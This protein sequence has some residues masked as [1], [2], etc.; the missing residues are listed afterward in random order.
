MEAFTHGLSYFLADPSVFL[1]LS[2]GVFFGI[3]FGAIPGLT[4]TLGV[5]LLLPFTYTMSPALGMSLL[6][7]IY[8]G[9]ISGGLITAILINI[10]GTPSSIITCFDGYPMAKNGRAGDALSIG[11]FASLVGGL[12]SA[13]ALIFISPPLSK[14]V[15][16]FGSWEYFTFALLGLSMV[17]SV[18]SKDIIKGLMGALLGLLLATVGMDTVT[19]MMRLT[20]GQWQLEGGISVTALMMGLFATREIMIQ[21]R[22]LGTGRG[23]VPSSNKVPFFPKWRDFRGTGVPFTLGPLIGIVMGIL[24]GIG[25]QTASLLTYN[26]SRQLSKHPEKFGTGI[27][28][29]IVA[30][31]SA[32][33]AVNGGALIALMTL[34]IPGDMVTA[35]L[36]GGLMIHGLQP[37]P[38]FFTTHIDIVGA[39]M[40]TYFVANIIMFIM[41]LGL[42][43]VFI[44]IVNVPYYFLFPT[45]IL[46]CI[47][48]VYAMNNRIFDIWILIGFGLAGYVLSEFEVDMEPLLL[49]FILGPLVEKNFRTALIGASGD[50]SEILTRPVA[51]TFLVL[52]IVFIIWPLLKAMMKQVGGNKPPKST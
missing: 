7:G 25:Q 24:P 27:P 3:V 37:G 12:I 42:M 29:G 39:V 48:G 38:L 35:V 20:V 31:E 23:K 41:L 13:L 11:V 51:T 40:V 21:S 17:V 15:L 16:I 14:I 44:K 30:S 5:V 9:G 52:S 46:T 8:V 32:N 49:G 36:L 34:G 43:K 1:V 26:Q 47:V 18:V 10:P 45:I 50:F 4:A 2:F 28:E 6:I 33:N 22:N 19:G